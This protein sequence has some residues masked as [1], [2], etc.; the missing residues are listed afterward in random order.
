MTTGLGEHQSKEKEVRWAGR[1][2]SWESGGLSS[3]PVPPGVTLVPKPVSL[4]RK[5]GVWPESLQKAL[6]ILML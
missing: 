1:I 3:V 5:R 4:T 6:A 2:G